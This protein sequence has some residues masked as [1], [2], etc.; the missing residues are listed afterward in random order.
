MDAVASNLE[1]RRTGRPIS[2]ISLPVGCSSCQLLYQ[3]DPVD[4]LHEK[5]VWIDV[6]AAS[7]YTNWKQSTGWPKW[8]TGLVNSVFENCFKAGSKPGVSPAA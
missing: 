2:Q 1:Q 3:A 5:V 4:R 7:Y 6:V 8:S